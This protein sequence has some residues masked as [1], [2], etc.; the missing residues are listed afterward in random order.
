LVALWHGGYPD[1]AR[2]ATD[3]ALRRTRQLRHI[4]T[5]VYALLII[6]LATI[7]ARRTVEAEELANEL[8]AL[9][10]EHR[11]A[12]FGIWPNLPRLGFSA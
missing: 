10:D 4:H 7:S 5:L 1:Q 6:I 9:S 11:F 3:E 12:L 8:V 2:K